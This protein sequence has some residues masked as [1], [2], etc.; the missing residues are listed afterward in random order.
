MDA[1][2]GNPPLV[3]DLRRL[4]EAD[5]VLDSETSGYGR[6]WTG[7]FQ[8]EPP[9]VVVPRSAE[10]VSAALA[11]CNERSIAVVPQGGNTGLV[12]GGVPC[13]G[14]IVLSLQHLN[15]LGTQGTVDTE[16]TVRVGAGMTLA[17]LQ[18]ALVPTGLRVPIDLG[19]RDSATLGGMASTNAGGHMAF[20]FGRMSHLVTAATVVTASGEVLTDDEAAWLA[21]GLEGTG[22]VVVDLE[23]RTRWVAQTQT[24][25][26]A[27]FT[28]S[29]EA[30]G[31]AMVLKE[32]MPTLVAAEY[33][34]ASTA[35]LIESVLGRALPEPVRAEHL[36]LLEAEDLPVDELAG[37]LERAG[38]HDVSVAQEPT[39][40]AALWLMRDGLTE[41]LQVAGPPLKLDVRVDPARV[42][43]YLKWLADAGTPHVFGHVLEGNLHVNF[44]GLPT[45]EHGRVARSVIEAAVAH[46]GRVAGEH[47]VGR[48]KRP[49]LDLEPERAALDRFDTMKTTFDPMR[50]MN[51]ALTVPIYEVP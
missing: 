26:L 25:M 51:P 22:G 29:E 13:D 42:P 43:A 14:E 37:L 35:D 32:R 39:Q 34:Q 3:T 44:L 19:A 1:P 38:V 30:V 24:T 12:G 27:R 20:R 40:A 47:G 36:L 41:A 15:T 11:Y 2:R 31:A 18:D 17:A 48:V 6:D 7:R 9:A 23:I 16:K 21:V 33:L 5:R 10:E 50:I 49:F 28:S 8:G 45:E 4:L 46:G